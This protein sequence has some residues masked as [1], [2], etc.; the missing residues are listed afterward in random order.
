[1][2][3]AEASGLDPQTRLL[4]ESNL[5]VLR[6]TGEWSEGARNSV[7]V[8]VGVMHQEYIQYLNREGVHVQPYITTGNGMDFMIGRL[9]FVFS[10]V[11]PCV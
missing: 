8:F 4:L 10:L 3:P 11:G 2:S 1:M 6:S 9:S 7:G 5:K